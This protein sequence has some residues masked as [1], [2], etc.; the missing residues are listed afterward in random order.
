MWG[1]APPPP[2]FGLLSTLANLAESIRTLN[3]AMSSSSVLVGAVPNKR[4]NPLSSHDH[5]DCADAC[6]ID[7][8]ITVLNTQVRAGTIECAMDPTRDSCK[9]RVNAANV[10][11]KRLHCIGGTIAINSSN[12]IFIGRPL[13]RHVLFGPFVGFWSR[14]NS[15]D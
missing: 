15:E 10:Q 13:R 4:V 2:H 14:I 9:Q 12:Y 11:G 8:A 5:A 1:L 6:N 3:Q 7:D